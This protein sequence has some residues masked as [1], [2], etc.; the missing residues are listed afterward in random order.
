MALSVRRLAV[1]SAVLFVLILAFLAGRV[2]AGADPA[3]TVAP[4]STTATD[5]YGSDAAPT[6]P[7]G[8]GGAAPYDDGSGGLAPYDDGSGGS[9][10]PDSD[11]PS[12]FAS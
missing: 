7:D 4:V 12:T 9:T 2:R 8:S 11:P 3:Q 1:I 10:A 6:G 5:P